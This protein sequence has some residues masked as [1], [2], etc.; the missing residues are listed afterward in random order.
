MSAR[1][2]LVATTVALALGAC[3]RPN[4]IR[5]EPDAEIEWV[6]EVPLDGGSPERGAWAAH[7]KM[8]EVVVI[9]APPE[10]S[11]GAVIGAMDALKQVGGKRM[12]LAAGARRRTKTIAFPST[13]EA[14]IPA[15]GEAPTVSLISVELVGDGTP[16]LG[17][18]HGVA[19]VRRALVRDVHDGGLPTI[20]VLRAAEDAPFARVLDVVD[21][22]QELGLRVVFTVSPRR[23]H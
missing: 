13:R 14:M 15:F 10:Q 23:Q 18:A 4:A 7:A 12:V 17:D 3:S 16:N 21:V 2:F 1:F 11:W 20:V 6:L 19:E 5:A 8:G 22:A 9:H